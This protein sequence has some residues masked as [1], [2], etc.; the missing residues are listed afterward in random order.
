MQYQS[1][2]E[3]TAQE[4]DH[5]RARVVEQLREQAYHDLAAQNP[6]SVVTIDAVHPSV[7]ESTAQRGAQAGVAAYVLDV[8][9]DYTV[10]GQPNPLAG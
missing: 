1:V 2:H 7:R 4:W 5:D 10:S 9:V 3:V 6:G 8:V